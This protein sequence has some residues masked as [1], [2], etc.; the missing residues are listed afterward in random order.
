MGKYGISFHCHTMLEGGKTRASYW[1]SSG[2]WPHSVGC[3]LPEWHLIAHDCPLHA[4]CP[5]WFL[6]WPLASLCLSHSFIIHDRQ[7]RSLTLEC[8]CVL[9]PHVAWELVQGATISLGLRVPVPGSD[10]HLANVLCCWLVVTTDHSAIS[11]LLAI[12]GGLLPGPVRHPLH[13]RE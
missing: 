5:L 8:I 6:F 12:W 4:S 1:G 7:L 2:R 13:V 9:A 3:H 11:A 10:G